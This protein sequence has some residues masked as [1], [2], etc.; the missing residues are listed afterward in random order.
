LLDGSVGLYSKWDVF[1]IIEKRAGVDLL[2]SLDAIDIPSGGVKHLLDNGLLLLLV[3][4]S[5][6]A[7]TA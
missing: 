2:I 3:E 5:V 7:K 1:G 4:D 6:G